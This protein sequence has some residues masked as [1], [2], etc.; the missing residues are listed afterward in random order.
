M[1]PAKTTIILP[2]YAMQVISVLAYS[3]ISRGRRMMMSA[4]I[5][6]RMVL[7]SEWYHGNDYC[8]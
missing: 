8:G 5:M 7:W 4:Y 6:V 3:Y 1:T 2:N